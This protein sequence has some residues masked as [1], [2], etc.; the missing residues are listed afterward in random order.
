MH[1]TCKLV[2]VTGVE[3]SHREDFSKGPRMKMNNLQPACNECS[4]SRLSHTAELFSSNVSGDKE[5][6][7]IS[8][9]A[10]WIRMPTVG[11]DMISETLINLDIFV[12]IDDLLALHCGL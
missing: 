10:T 3:L 1:S 8:E 4:F 9:S 12:H 2:L 5:K 7:Q 6:K 11:R